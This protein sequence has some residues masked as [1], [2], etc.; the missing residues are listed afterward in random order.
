MVALAPGL[1]VC[2]WRAAAMSRQWGHAP[3]S[4]QRFRTSK[5]AP[6]AFD[7]QWGEMN[8]RI[9]VAGTK[10]LATSKSFLTCAPFSFTI[11]GRWIFRLR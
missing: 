2:G 3:P 5:S 6:D 4:I 7:H 1:T 11:S 9:C 8:F 10:Y